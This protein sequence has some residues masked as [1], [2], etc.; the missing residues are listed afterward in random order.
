M[1][2]EE[3][4][5][6]ILELVRE[7]ACVAHTP[8]TFE[9]GTSRVPVAGRVYGAREL[10]L[11]T[12]AG[13]EFWLTAGHFNR[14]F[15]QKLADF[16]KVKYVSTT[17]SGSSANLLAVAALTSPKLGKRALKPGDEVI[18]AAACFPTTVNPLL[19]Y[20]LVPVFVD[21][22][23]PTYNVP[24]QLVEAAITPKT[25]AIFLAHMLGNPFE[26]DKIAKLA[27]RHDLWLIEDCCDALG[28]TYGD[29]MA[30]TFGHIGTASFYPAHHITMGEGGALFTKDAEL[31]RLIDSFRDW[32]RD[33]YCEPGQDN[34]CGK[35]FSWK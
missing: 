25:R 2:T 4:R 5:Q 19:L 28:S 35:R 12:E 21:V 27:K 13:L 1:K 29:K 31:K 16:L 20:G 6:K 9:P 30:G 8:G 7:Y 14:E 26:A 17:N 15:E 11:L 10:E 34:T 22:H 33:C 24:A 32:G 23:V 18:T 3:L